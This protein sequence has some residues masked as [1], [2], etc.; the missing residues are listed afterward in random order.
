VKQT[1]LNC[2]GGERKGGRNFSGCEASQAAVW[3]KQ[4]SVRT[5]KKTQHFTITK[6]NCLTLFKEM[7]AVYSDSHMKPVHTLC[8]Q[9]AELME[10]KLSRAHAA[11]YFK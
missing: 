2:T 1:A 4:Y 8:G 3:T 5:A 10:T 6:I 9:N 7:I 11:L